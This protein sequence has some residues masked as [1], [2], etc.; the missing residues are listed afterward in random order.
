MNEEGVGQGYIDGTGTRSSSDRWLGDAT[1]LPSL[2]AEKP[3]CRNAA[4]AKN[5]GK[6]NKKDNKVWL[7]VRVFCEPR[8]YLGSEN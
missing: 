4:E 5:N 2:T 8:F 3:C 7:S 1:A 6:V